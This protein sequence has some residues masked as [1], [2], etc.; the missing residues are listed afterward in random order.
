MKYF[1]IRKDIL[2]TLAYFEMFDYPL[3]KKEIFS[4]LGHCND[5]LEFD[6]ALNSLLKDYAIFKLGDLYSLKNDFKQVVRRNNGNERAE[7]MLHKANTAAAI[8]AAFPFVK[9]VAIS[10]SLS[11]YF[12]DENSDID[13]FIITTANRLWIARTFLHIFKKFTFLIR[14]QHSF[15]MNY[16]IDEEEP[17]ILEKNIYTAVE[18][19]TIMPLYGTNV[20]NHFFE[21]NKWAGNFLPNRLL[22]TGTACKPGNTWFKSLTEKAFNNRFGNILDDYLMRLTEKSWNLKTQTNKKDSKG[23]LMSMHAGKHFSKASPEIFQKMILQRY[24]NSLSEIFRQFDLS[25][26]K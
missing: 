21:E 15:C 18:T 22:R 12:A 24:E 13:F 11:K 16:F 19:A 26:A 25:L 3:K 7:K 20:F 8:I 2:A 9:G 14:R 10:G 4:F 17:V 23:V 5:Y 6:N 1:T